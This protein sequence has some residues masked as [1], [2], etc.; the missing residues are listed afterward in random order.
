MQKKTHR[1]NWLDFLRGL[2]LVLMI[3]YHTLW[4]L[5]NLFGRTI[6]WFTDS[7]A[8]LL[9]RIICISFIL[10]SGYSIGLSRHGIRKGVMVF[11]S[12]ILVSVVTYF[13]VPDSI[14]IFGVLTFLGVAM[15]LTT[16][17]KS[18]LN[19]WTPIIGALVFFILFLLFYRVNQGQLGFLG[20]PIATFSGSLYKNYVT[21]FFGFPFPGFYSTDYFSF[22]PWIFLY[23]VGYYLYL[24]TQRF[25]KK[26]FGPIRKWGLISF[27]GRYTLP[28]YLIH[29]II[30][31]GVMYFIF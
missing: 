20:F 2:A 28:I 29:Q 19:H 21:T 15:I 24:L 16:L 30:I 7:R 23:F 12:G 18:Q 1:A 13:F 26:S 27:L 8:F 31:Y 5:E 22:L 11:A 25:A 10:I 4:D 3:I 17:I 6:P 14:I 9:E